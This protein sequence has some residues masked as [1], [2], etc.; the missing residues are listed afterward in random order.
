MI[1]VIGLGLRQ[2]SLPG[3]L[4]RIVGQA[5]VL[6]GGKE[7][8]AMFPGHK[9]ET[10]LIT[11]P[12]S[13]AMEKVRKCL[14]QGR[15]IVALA[16]GDPMCFGLGATMVARFGIKNVLVH[17]NVSCIQAASSRIGINWSVLDIVSLHG[18]DNW[19]NLFSALTHSPWV[20]VLTDPANTP[21]RI[22]KACI[23][24]GMESCICHVFEDLEGD[25][26]NYS[27][28]S[29]EQAGELEFAAPNLLVLEQPDFTAPRLGL[30]DHGFIREKGL[31][32]KSAVRAASLFHLELE[33]GHVL[34]DIGAGCGSVSIEAASMLR[35]GM[36]VAVER[37]PERM[38][39]IRRNIKKFKT[40][41]VK[42]VPGNA[43]DVL[44]SLPKP[45]R[46]FMGGGARDKELLR[47]VMRGLKPGGRLVV[48]CILL[49]TM[50]QVASFLSESGWEA[51]ITQ[52]S[53]AVSE[54]LAGDMRLKA[55]NPVFIVHG[56]KPLQQRIQD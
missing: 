50:H 27:A 35:N 31:I 55:Q 56:E 49:G 48:N 37:I 13:E 10:I 8:L 9:G 42:P 26:E 40:W 44:D 4:Q 29:L 22:A 3:Y 17:P 12:I 11:S 21:G 45:D 2:N 52:V 14:D 23:E 41:L 20:C 33:P 30:P 51:G 53:A 28:L 1:Q 32:T 15:H 47:E 36:A 24:Q 6:V 7:Q 54:T 38:D 39:M 25:N 43:L 34:W 5:D 46:V 19:R 18:R 16:H